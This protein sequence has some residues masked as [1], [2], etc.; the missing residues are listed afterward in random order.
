MCDR[1]VEGGILCDAARA[2]DVL[3]GLGA[4]VRTLEVVAT[5]LPGARE[6]AASDCRGFGVTLLSAEGNL[7][8][9]CIDGPGVLR[10]FCLGLGSGADASDIGGDGGSWISDRVSAVATDLESGG[11]VMSGELA[12]ELGE[13]SYEGE[14]GT[15][16]SVESAERCRKSWSLSF[17]CRI[18]TSILRSESSSFSR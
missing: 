18:S 17:P 6:V 10:G 8:F 4:G 7:D 14:S 9:L 13:W 3:V 11:V 1:D 5:R 15:D 2:T 16:I 12:V